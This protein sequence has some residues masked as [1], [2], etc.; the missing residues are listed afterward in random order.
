LSGD[1]RQSD[2]CQPPTRSPLR[3]HHVMQRRPSW[4]ARASH[5]DAADARD[6]ASL[7]HG[8][9]FWL[10]PLRLTPAKPALACTETSLS[11]RFRWMPRCASRVRTAPGWSA[12]YPCYPLPRGGR[13]AGAEGTLPGHTWP[14]RWMGRLCSW[15]Y[16][17]PWVIR[18]SVDALTLGAAG[19][20]GAA[21]QA[22]LLILV[23]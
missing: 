3:D 13:G 1:R 11:L 5:L 7:D 22:V 8:G 2:C 21:P 15:R 23:K 10:R 12:C 19:G 9:G 18:T 14:S 17:T 4:F 6:M 20:T 16:A